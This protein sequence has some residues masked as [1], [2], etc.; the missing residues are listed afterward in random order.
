MHIY[1]KRCQDVTDALPFL[2]NLLCLR[3]TDSRA[4]MTAKVVVPSSSRH[5]RRLAVDKVSET[6]TTLHV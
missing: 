3:G 5:T 6:T 1:F 4:D 2:F